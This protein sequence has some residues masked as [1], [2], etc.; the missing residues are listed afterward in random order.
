[1]AIT[2][3]ILNHFTPEEAF[4]NNFKALKQ[5]ANDYDQWFLNFDTDPAEH[6]TNFIQDNSIA[7]PQSCPD[8]D[9]I[10]HDTI[11]DPYIAITGAV[12]N[13]LANNLIT[14][15]ANLSSFADANQVF[16]S[17]TQSDPHSLSY[18]TDDGTY[19]FMA[20][21]TKFLIAVKQS[22]HRNRRNFKL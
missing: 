11:D 3:P 18:N 4:K 21:L 20:D 8:H 2:N 13:D 5:H 15:V 1:M 12:P 17:I 16:N 14:V 6:M 19:T 22:D 7:L 10:I 9:L